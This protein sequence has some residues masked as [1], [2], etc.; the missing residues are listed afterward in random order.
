M[1]GC[2]TQ[3]LLGFRGWK[4]IDGLTRMTSRFE[5]LVDE[6]PLELGMWVVARR[7]LFLHGITR[8]NE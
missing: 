3:E 8:L 2:D 1:L 6:H 5:E 4:L 7:D